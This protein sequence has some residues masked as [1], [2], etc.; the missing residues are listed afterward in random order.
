MNKL[1]DNVVA[2]YA[3]RCFDRD[4]GEVLVPPFKATEGA[5]KNVFKGEALPLTKEAVDRSELDSEGR[6]FR[7]ATGWGQLR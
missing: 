4:A 6:W 5:I 7:M 3:L 1:P 2:V